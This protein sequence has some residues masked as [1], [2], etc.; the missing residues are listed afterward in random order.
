MAHIHK[1]KLSLRISGDSLVPEEIT[2]LLG[3]APTISHAKDEEIRNNQTCSARIARSG[4]WLLSVDDRS[5]E[6][7]DGQLRGLFDRLTSDLD[8]WRKIGEDYSADLF[9]GFFMQGFNEGLTIS[10]SVMKMISDRRLEIGFDVYGGD[11][12]AF[13]S[14]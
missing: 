10:A 6:N 13:N 12:R 8:V 2:K 11:E 9:C 1:S 4:M 7:L 14:E 5:P 3:D